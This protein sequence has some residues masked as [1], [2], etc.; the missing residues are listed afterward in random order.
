MNHAEQHT[1]RRTLASSIRTQECSDS[2]GFDSHGEIADHLAF[3][4]RFP[5][6]FGLDYGIV[7][8]ALRPNFRIKFGFESTS[9]FFVPK[10]LFAKPSYDASERP[11]SLLHLICNRPASLHSNES[12]RAV[13]QLKQTFM[14]ELGV[15]LGY[16]IGTD[17]KVFG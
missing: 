10:T 15:R 5:K 16:R 3:A 2:A 9:D 13:S 1:N 8:T 11:C 12:T 17:H 7:H 6:A 4:V 14:L